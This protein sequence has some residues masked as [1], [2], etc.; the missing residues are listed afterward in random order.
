MNTINIVLS[1]EDLAGLKKT[2]VGQGGFQDLLRRL[3]GYVVPD[4]SKIE[5]PIS[6]LEPIVRYV[7]LYGQ[8]GFQERL[9]PLVDPIREIERA[10]L[11]GMAQSRRMSRRACPDCSTTVD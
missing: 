8:G 1:D 2:V 5:I 10:V 7:E 4:S 9:K 6:E 3:K 11:S